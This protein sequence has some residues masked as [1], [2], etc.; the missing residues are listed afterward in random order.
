MAVK[1]TAAEFQI[2]LKIALKGSKGMT[3]DERDALVT[4]KQ[5]RVIVLDA[6]ADVVLSAGANVLIDT[7]LDATAFKTGSVGYMLYS[8][9]EF[10]G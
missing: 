5:V 8:K 3:A 9:A 2:G 7:V 6:S 10:S 1:R 4:G